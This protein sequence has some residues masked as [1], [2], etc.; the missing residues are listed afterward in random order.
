MPDSITSLEGETVSYNCTVHSYLTVT[1]AWY[2]GNGTLITSS[3][4]LLTINNV[5]SNDR[6]VYYCEA[7]D[8]EGIYTPRRMNVSL[9]VRCKCVCLCVCL[10]VCFFLF[11]CCCYCK[12]IGASINGPSK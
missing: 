12:Y 9:I 5:T 8:V 11:I 10:F 2:H 7:A 1:M 4:G 3:D 6:G